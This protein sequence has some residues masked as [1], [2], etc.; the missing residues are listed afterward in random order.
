[1]DVGFQTLNG[2]K[3]DCSISERMLWFLNSVNRKS[4]RLLRMIE[5]RNMEKYGFRMDFTECP[6]NLLEMKT[7]ETSKR[8][9]FYTRDCWRR[10]R[11]H[12]N[13]TVGA[14]R[15]VAFPRLMRAMVILYFAE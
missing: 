4:R 12:V 10:F 2:L 5:S 14:V 6:R 9:R 11:C 1:M 15:T 7:T 13:S 8:D 3:D